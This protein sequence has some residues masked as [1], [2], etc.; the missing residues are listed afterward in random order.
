MQDVLGYSGD[1]AALFYMIGS[2]FGPVTGVVFGG[3]VVSVCGGY[4]SKKGQLAMTYFAVCALICILPLP[5]VT[6]KAFFG[7]GVF[8]LLFFG[9]AMVP[10]CTGIMLNTVP[11]DLR[12]SANSLA[13]IIY[14]FGGYLPAP[15]FYGTISKLVNDPTSRIPFSALMVTG[16]IPMTLLFTN[17]RAKVAKEEQ[18]FESPEMLAET[19]QSAGDVSTADK[20]EST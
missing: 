4:N 10:T 20:D 17:I 3:I 16:F 9:G 14:N 15:V 1:E 8:G 6:R 13:M 19:G 12:T 5:F 11:E 18:N 7:P 2:F